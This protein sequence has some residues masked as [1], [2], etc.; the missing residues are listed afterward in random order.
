V[1]EIAG[2]RQLI[3]KLHPN[4]RR[5]RSIQ[6]IRKMAPSALIFTEGSAEEM[7]A[8]CK[9]LVVQYSS[10]AYVGLALGK[11]VRSLFD[12]ALLKRLLPVQNR[13]AALR[14]AAVGCQLLGLRP[15]AL[16]EAPVYSQPSWVA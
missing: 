10:L 4:E 9:V 11:E 6:E 15:P 5:D 2:G 13:S 16:E 1:S 8:N 12:L 3:F 14:I 7:I